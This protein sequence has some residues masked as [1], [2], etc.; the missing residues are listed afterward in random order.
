[1]RFFP[2]MAQIRSWLQEKRLGQVRLVQ[3]EFCIQRPYDPDHRLFNPVLGGGALLDLG[4]YPLSFATMVLGFPQ[5]IH[6]HAH[7]GRSGVD[8]LDSIMF[9]YENGATANLVCSLRIDKPRE[10]FIVGTKGFIKVHELFLRPDV[11]TFKQLDREPE[12]LHM[13]FRSN[14]Y[15]HEVEEVHACLQEGRT[16]SAIM[17]LHETMALM[18]IMDG[19][20]AQWGVT[21]PGEG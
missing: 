19:L 5:T 21:Y 4:I 7:C 12:V 6:S 15:V 10:A 13:P 8:E 9:V 16:E 1:M 20:R 11:I 18:E 14:G 2:A 3:A 17:P